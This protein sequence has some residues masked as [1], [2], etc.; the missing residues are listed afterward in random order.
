MNRILAWWTCI[1]HGP[2]FQVK[3]RLPKT[4]KKHEL[5]HTQ[6]RM[7]N[8]PSSSHLIS[9][10]NTTAHSQLDM[11]SNLH[12][13]TC[14]PSSSYFRTP[15]KTPFI[16]SHVS[17]NISRLAHTCATQYFRS[18]SL[19]GWQIV[20]SID[21]LMNSY[22]FAWNR[23]SDVHCLVK[24]TFFFHSFP[25]SSFSF[26][27]SMHPCSFIP[28]SPS[29]ALSHTTLLPIRF[30]YSYLKRL[31][32]F[33]STPQTTT[34]SNHDDPDRCERCGG[35]DPALDAVQAAPRGRY[36]A[37]LWKGNTQPCSMER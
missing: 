30:V 4:K 31:A 26:I 2:G 35:M 10:A 23:Q 8:R 1:L 25:F 15:I 21:P 33:T 32:S 37:T 27:I 11:T 13:L 17:L 9:S 28:T 6:A 12:T 22:W 34:T 20:H 16:A 14:W 19:N 24:L 18:F 3:I 36:Q 5:A 7:H 29:R